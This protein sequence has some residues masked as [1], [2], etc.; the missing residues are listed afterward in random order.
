MG[1]S[2]R[3][4]SN[5]PHLSNVDIGTGLHVFDHG[6]WHLWSVAG[7]YHKVHQFESSPP[8]NRDCKRSPA[9]KYEC[10]W[11]ILSDLE[12][13]ENGARKVTLR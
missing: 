12:R 10:D 2:K 9:G 4:N 5:Y 13:L 3:I 11:A 6:N 8:T 1:Y 7:T